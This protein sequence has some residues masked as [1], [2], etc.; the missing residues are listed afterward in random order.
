MDR[1]RIIGR[2]NIRVKLTNYSILRSSNSGKKFII[3]FI[4]NIPNLF[5]WY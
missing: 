4:K 5:L 1:N 2:K 3:K